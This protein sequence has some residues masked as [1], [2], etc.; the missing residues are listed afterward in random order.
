M[1]VFYVMSGGI[2]PFDDASHTADVENNIINGNSDLSSLQDSLAVDMVETMLA[3]NP[4]DR[5]STQTLLG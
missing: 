2:H 4:A 3:A 5:P 1:V